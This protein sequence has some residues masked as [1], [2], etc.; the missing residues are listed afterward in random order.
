MK[1][2]N[3]NGGP[4]LT[5]HFCHTC[6][7]PRLCDCMHMPVCIAKCRISVLSQ[8][9]Y[10]ADCSSVGASTHHRNITEQKQS[11]LTTLL[12]VS[13]LHRIQYCIQS[14][15]YNIVSYGLQYCVHLTHICAYKIS[16]SL[17][18]TNLCSYLVQQK[19]LC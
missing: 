14:I 10:R 12:V 2:T 13:G 8:A 11:T 17:W 3:T 1:Q 18:H 15:G 7:P 6:K 19:Y 16:L 4:R 9:G 5:P